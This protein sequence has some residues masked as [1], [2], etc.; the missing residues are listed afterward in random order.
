ME[1][2]I[3]FVNRRSDLWQQLAELK[4]PP[5]PSEIHPML[6][7]NKG[8]VSWI[9][10]TYLHLRRHGANVQ[11]SDTIRPGAINI[12]HYDDLGW[13]RLPFRGFVVAVQ[14]DRP[15]PEIA[16]LRIVQNHL[17]IRN[18]A[19]D[20][21]IPH[22][23]QPGLQHR[24]PARGDRLERLAYYGLDVYLAPEFHNQQFK[25]ELNKIGITFDICTNPEKWTDYTQT[26]AVLA[27]RQSTDYVLSIKPPTKLINAF[28]A[29]SI[30]ILGAEPAYRQIATPGQDYFEATTPEQVI[31]ILKQLKSNPNLLRQT[32]ARLTQRAAEFTND[33]IAQ[34]WLN[35]LHGPVYERYQQWQKRRHPVRLLLAALAYPGQLYSHR[36]E[37]QFFLKNNPEFVSY[38]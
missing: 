35:L 1:A 15:R 28:L 13:K 38:R 7:I 23:S 11:M 5:L 33:R 9:I 17:C 4:S 18:P 32:Q 12:I 8:S 20:Y 34:C 19:T 22:W 14:S 2:T 25:A 36:A 3:Y 37:R 26:D 30:P 27:I 29:G 24:D 21:Y 16:N 31:A 6:P 10:Q